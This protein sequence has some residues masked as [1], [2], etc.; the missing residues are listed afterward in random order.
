LLYSTQSVIKLYS[1]IDPFLR[2]DFISVQ[3]TCRPASLQEGQALKISFIKSHNRPSTVTLI[4]RRPGFYKS[5]SI[6]KLRKNAFREMPSTDRFFGSIPRVS[7]RSQINLVF[8]KGGFI[9]ED[10]SGSLIPLCRSDRLTPAAPGWLE[11]RPSS[12][13]PN[14]QVQACNLVQIQLYVWGQ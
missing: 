14:G 12:N 3:F 4:R 6:R 5:D 8:A 7:E 11:S 9:L 13:L 10:S 2:E 1:L